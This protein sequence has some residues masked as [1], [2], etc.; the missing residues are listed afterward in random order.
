MLRALYRTVVPAVVRDWIYIQRHADARQ[1]HRFQHRDAIRAFL[2]EVA[3]SGWF[4]GVVL[5]VGSGQE[6]F[7][8]DVFC[9]ANPRLKFLRSEISPGGYGQQATIP[10]GF[11]ALYTSVTALGLRSGSLDG[12]LCSEVLEHV[13]DF[14]AA[15][16]EMARVLKPGGRLLITC[17]F[18]Y[19]LHGPQDYWRFTPQ[20]FEYLLAKDFTIN[21]IHKALLEP[22]ADNAPLNIGVLATRR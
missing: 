13:A 5:E 19:P 11:Y 14:P 17:P 18:L 9:A 16:R 15:L 12:I 4:H 21:R 22:G 1:Y 8:R 6:T 7:A 2:A 3:R 10:R 20:A